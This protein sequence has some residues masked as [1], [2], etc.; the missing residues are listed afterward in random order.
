MILERRSLWKDKP[1]G[2]VAIN[3]AHPLAPRLLFLL[4][5]GAG[6]P[7]SLP[8]G[9]VGQLPPS[10]AVVT[11]QTGANGLGAGFDPSL[12]RYVSF[13]STPSIWAT[14]PPF[15]VE[16][17]WDWASTEVASNAFAGPV[18]NRVSGQAGFRFVNATGGTTTFVPQ[19][20]VYDGASETSNWKTG[21]TYTQPFNK[22]FLW[23]WDGT[24]AACYVDGVLDPV[25]STSGGFGTSVDMPNLG[26]GYGGAIGGK[27]IKVA[28]YPRA[29][30]ALEAL[31][32]ATEPYV[33]LQPVLRRRYFHFTPAVAP[34]AVTGFAFHERLVG[35]GIAKGVM[36]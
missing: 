12:A 25:S 22:K 30:S 16:A 6:Q 23:T 26:A 21:T 15:S 29:L 18:G 1:T 7:R 5:E 31:W 2:G 10:G 32:L 13:V 20:V 8:F 35:R 27:L 4:N 36:R 9:T 3:P 33:M 11:W 19:L 34:P 14:N 28:I 17:W 24:T